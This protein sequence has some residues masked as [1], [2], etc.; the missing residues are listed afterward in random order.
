MLV[1][2]LAGSLSAIIINRVLGHYGGDYAISTF[3]IINRIMMFAIMPGIVISQGLQPLLGYN[4]GA[5]RYG[6]ALKSMLLA[7]GAAMVFC[8]LSFGFLYFLPHVFIK[9]FTNDPRLIAD[10]V[11]ASK[12]IYFFLYLVGVAFV[13]MMS[14][15][16]R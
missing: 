7:I 6:L 15:P 5:R 13:G 14:T 2:T 10:A 9:V 8:I 3:G 1:M 11:H 12:R 16:T 4:Y